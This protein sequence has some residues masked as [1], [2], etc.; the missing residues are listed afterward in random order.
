[1]IDTDPLHATVNT[2]L[3]TIDLKPNTKPVAVAFDHDSHWAYVVNA[4]SNNV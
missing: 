2:V 3:T 4:G 1:M